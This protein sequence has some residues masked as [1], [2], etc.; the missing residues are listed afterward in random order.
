MKKGFT[1]IELI[2]YLGLAAT[3]IL[4]VSLFFIAMLS[5]R[6]KQQAIAEVEQQGARVM[7]IITQA[8]RNADTITSPGTGSSASLLTLDMVPTAVDPTLFD[9]SSGLIRITEGVGSAVALTNSRITASLLTFQNLSRASTPGTI[10]I[11]FTL[12]HLNPTGRNEY[13][14]SKTFYGSASLR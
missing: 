1:L 5:S 14:Y 6:I 12:S 9:L 3:I 8:T 2:L 10:R 11:Q 4:A 7:H 13:E